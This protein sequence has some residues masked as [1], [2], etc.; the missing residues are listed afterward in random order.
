MQPETKICQNCKNEFEIISE[1]FILYE[2]I[3]LQAPKVCFECRSK[4]YFAFWPFGKFRKSKSDLSG[5]GLITVLPNNPRYPIYKSE[6]WWSDKWDPIDS[7]QEYDPSR[8]FFEQ[9][10]ELQEKIPR[11]HQTGESSINCDW[12]D[13]IWDSKNCYLSRSLSRCENT[14]YSYRVLNTKDSFDIVLSF[15]LQNSY[16]CLSCHNSYNLNF[17]ESSRDCVDSYFL[18]DCRNCQNCFMCFNLRNKSYCILNKQYSKEEYFSELKKIKFDSY[19]YLLS[20]KEKFVEILKSNA[21][22]KENHNIN[23]LNSKGNYLK[24]CENCVNVFSWENSQNCRNSLRGLLSKDCIDQL[25][26]WHTEVSGDNSCVTGGY[27]IK[28]SSWSDARYSEYLDLCYEVE[29][30]FG[31]IGLRNKKHCILNKQYTKEEYENLKSKIIENMKSKG[32]YGDFL[33]YFMGLCPYNFSTAIIYFPELQK[34]EIDRLNGYWSSEDLSSSE[35]DNSMGLPDSI[36]E[37]NISISDK[38]LICPES[39]YRFNISKAEYD[40]HKR[41]GF[42]LP[43]LHFDLRVI[44]KA[45]KASVIKSFLYKCF[46]CK[47]DIMAY[48]PYEWGYKNIACEEC[49]K[50]NIN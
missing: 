41:K 46:F 1:D 17:S 3:G 34:S 4:N 42:A 15:N 33:P 7:G 45:R 50:I 30:C 39:H 11:P 32:E 21:I 25:G 31:C 40:F 43:R 2:K 37:T 14:N 28:H 23:V 26:T 6:E 27:D 35:G 22:H 16:D 36:F 24:D 10:K 5:D 9:L 47:K 19:G 29:Y 44:K 38:A 12:C 13:D 20:L 49:Y 48:Y 8:S 18:F